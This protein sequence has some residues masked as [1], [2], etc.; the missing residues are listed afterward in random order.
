MA[1]REYPGGTP[2]HEPTPLNRQ[3]VIA[4]SCAGFNHE[5]IAAYLRI[6]DKTL[7][8]HYRA[9]LDDAKLDKI[10]HI[11]NNVY[12]KAMDGD[13]EMAKFVLKCQGRWSYAKP[14]EES[15][16][17]QIGKTIL[18]QLQMDKS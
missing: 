10:A 9:E 5:Q 1:E 18:E 15:I 8:K 7:R 2:E 13:D 4:F 14:A 3:K 16:G 6:D 17:E 12:K 11:S